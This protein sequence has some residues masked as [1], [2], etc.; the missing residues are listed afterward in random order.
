MLARSRLYARRSRGCPIVWV[1]ELRVARLVGALG[2]LTSRTGTVW[3][4]TIKNS[5]TATT[6]SAPMLD[7]SSLHA[8]LACRATQGRGPGPA[9]APST[10]KSQAENRA[11]GAEALNYKPGSWNIIMVKQ[12]EIPA[13][14]CTK[15]MLPLAGSHRRIRSQS[16]DPSPKIRAPNPNSKCIRN[17]TGWSWR[18]WVGGGGWLLG[19]PLS[20]KRPRPRTRSPEPS[21]TTGTRGGGRDAQEKTRGRPAWRRRMI[22]N[23]VFRLRFMGLEG[24]E[25]RVTRFLSVLITRVVTRSRMVS[26]NLNAGCA[27]GVVQRCARCL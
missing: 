14:I 8:I 7:I 5:N 3:A 22:G 20:P 9:R 15:P 1:S 10:K 16:P 23:S 13:L 26:F 12:K 18:G 17:P 25:N 24:V 2:D 19:N 6:Y 21:P 11:Q 27:T 4:G